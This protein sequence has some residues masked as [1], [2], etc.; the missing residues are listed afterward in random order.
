MKKTILIIGVLVCSASIFTNLCA[1]PVAAS[2]RAAAF[3]WLSTAFDFGEIPQNKPVSHTF[4]FTNNGDEP[5]VISSVQAS[6]GCTVA[7]YS[8]DPVLPGG[9]GYVTATYN[10]AKLGAFNK[11][12]TVNANADTGAV[13][14]TVKGTVVE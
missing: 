13:L 9:E 5:L 6:C 11:T 7:A 3:A 14:L 12:L 10:A 2:W 1:N 8:K 4:R